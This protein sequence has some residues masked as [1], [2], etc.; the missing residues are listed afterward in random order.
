LPY[1]EGKKRG[2]RDWQK[3]CKGSQKWE[4]G[5]SFC[6][7]VISESIIPFGGFILVEYTDRILGKLLQ[8]LSNLESKLNILFIFD[9]LCYYIT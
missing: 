9:L 1:L 3:S 4:T 5:F 2:Q 7:G 6:S 8:Y